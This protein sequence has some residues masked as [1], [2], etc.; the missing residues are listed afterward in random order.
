[1]VYLVYIAAILLEIIGSY[2]S[3]IG[4]SQKTIFLIVFIIITLDFSKVIMVSVLY[5][6]W[7]EVPILMK[8]ILSISFVLLMAVTSFSTYAYLIQELNK[9]SVA[10]QQEK[11]R[12]LDL[13]EEKT[14][15]LKRKVE[16]DSQI[17]SLPTE[18][19][20]QKRKMFDLFSNEINYINKRIIDLDQEIPIE[21]DKVIEVGTHS[22]TIMNIATAYNIDIKDVNKIFALLLVFLI[23]PLAITLL[24]MANFLMFKKN[25]GKKSVVNEDINLKNG[26]DMTI[27]KNKDMGGGFDL[28]DMFG[29]SNDDLKLRGVGVVSKKMFSKDKKPVK[30]VLDL[31][32]KKPGVDVKEVAYDNEV[33]KVV[34]SNLPESVYL[35]D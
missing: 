34:P 3:I 4:I 13:T 1:M 27:L 25:V 12:V 7:K 28:K 22:G 16:I 31:N 14:R 23:D 30:S 10:V 26:E 32:S 9:S 5:K 11:V 33:K 24:T 20:G 17:S 6:Y 15:L 2:M 29:F 19:V 35:E 8:L 18:Y 21:N